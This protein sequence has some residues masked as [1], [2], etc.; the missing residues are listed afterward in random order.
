MSCS[1]FDLKDYFF[2]ELG[3]S[4]RG[5]VETH[6]KE[7]RACREDIERLHLTHAALHALPQE[8]PPRRIAFV[9]DKVFAPRWWQA[10]WNSAAR[11]GFAGATMLSIAILVHGFARPSAVVPAPG[12]T[13]MEARISA[14]VAR[15]VEAAVQQAVAA[16]E[17]RQSAKA[18]QMVEAVRRDFEF[19]RRADRLEYQETL[20]ILQKR[21]GGLLVASSELG[22]RP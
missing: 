18:N 14:E 13:A 21:W 4:E 12:A 1:P 8:E 10:W 3:G 9:S 20:N 11:L 2:G 17:A 7:C 16:S 19:Q 6:L 15:R 5:Q 22:G